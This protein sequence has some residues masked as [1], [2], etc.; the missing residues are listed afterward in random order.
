MHAKIGWFNVI[1]KYNSENKRGCDKLLIP[2][3]H[4]IMY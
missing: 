4:E 2:F 3:K 1:L